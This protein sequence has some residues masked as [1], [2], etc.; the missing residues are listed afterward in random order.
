M[1]ESE[2]RQHPTIPRGQGFRSSLEAS[3]P[4]SKYRT[5][6]IFDRFDQKS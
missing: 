2:N 4:H 5:T 6:M 1:T 3:F